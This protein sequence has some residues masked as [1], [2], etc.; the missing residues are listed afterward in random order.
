MFLFLS[1][2]KSFNKWYTKFTRRDQQPLEINHEE[3][4]SQLQPN[5]EPQVALPL[6]VELVPVPCWY[7][8][9]RSILPKAQWDQLRKKSCKDAGYRCQVCDKQP[10]ESLECHEMW[11]Y[12][13]VK[14][15][16]VLKGLTA[17]CFSC[18]LAKHIGQANV[19][20]KGNEALEHLK[21]INGMTAQEAEK[22]VDE[23][24]SLWNFRNI[25]HWNI[26]L[27]WLRKQGLSLPEISGEPKRLRLDPVRLNFV[28]SSNTYL[29]AGLSQPRD[30]WP[31]LMDSCKE[32]SAAALELILPLNPVYAM[33]HVGAK[34]IVFDFVQN[35]LIVDDVFVQFNLVLPN[36]LNEK[37]DADKKCLGLCHAHV[38]ISLLPMTENQHFSPLNSKCLA[39]LQGLCPETYPYS[40]GQ[41]E[42][43]GDMLTRWLTKTDLALV[44]PQNAGNVPNI[45]FETS[46]SN[47]S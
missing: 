14:K 12:D 9:L 16:Q 2:F 15:T 34:K 21:K 39:L 31:A 23:C 3:D 30:V 45:L 6:T 43:Q 25:F 37:F 1:V 20:G 24:F 18:H 41:Y 36:P 7:S 44:W 32:G 28:M 47:K 42:V 11:Y 5:P 33:D 46:S 26:D 29:Q 27:S 19:Q 40:P 38:L 10:L 17:L 8:N 35:H 4:L 22:Y 13:D